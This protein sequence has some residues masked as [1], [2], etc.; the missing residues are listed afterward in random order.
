MDELRQNAANLAVAEEKQPQ[1][2]K[3]GGK[4]SFRR[5]GFEGLIWI[6]PAFVLMLIFSYYP[7]V[8]AFYHSLTNWNGTTAS[9]IGLKNFT[10]LFQDT[11]FWRSCWTMVVLTLSCM[12]IGNICTIVLAELIYNCSNKR[13][14]S[15]YRFMFVIPAIIPGIVTIMLWGKI[16]LSGQSNGVLNTILGA[17][18]I[19]PLGWFYSEDTVLWSI[20]LYGFPWM[21]GTSFLIYLAGLNNISE[22][23]VEASKLDGIGTFKRVL[24]IDLPMLKGQIKYFL[25]MGLIGGIQ[26]YT[27]Q[28]A[29]TNGGPGD[30]YASMVPGYYMYKAAINDSEYGYSCAM[31]VVLFLMILVI[32]I[33]NNK[34]I[35]TEED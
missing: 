28:Y 15:F 8:D 19:K 27:L 13:M 23:V 5:S 16:I 12:L 10:R 25:I 33:I 18:G 11:L 31:G 4:K 2:G 24:F 1:K 34:F 20:I 29:I 22:S 26:G 14:S 21:G 3:K 9:W 7:P 35:K 32:T 17:F 30:S 6:A